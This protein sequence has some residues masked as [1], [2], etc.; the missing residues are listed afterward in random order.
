MKKA[1]INWSSGKDA[2]FT[3]YKVRKEGNFSVESLVTTINLETERISMHGVR[4]ELLESQAEQV[5][6]P[7]K[8][9]SLAGNVSMTSYNEIMLKQTRELKLQGYTHSIYGDIFLEDLKKYREDQLD[10]VGLT[11]VFP[12]WKTD[13]R[14][15]IKDFI[16]AGFKAKVVCVN[17]RLL[18]KSF[19]GREIDE[20]FLSS[21]PEG[22][23]PCGE[24]GEFHTFV[25]D[26]PVFKNPIRFEIGQVVQRSFQSSANKNDNCF[27]DQEKSW[28]TNFWYCDLL[29]Q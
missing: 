23:D 10:E 21:L 14:Q 7:L 2:A 8:L 6:L 12:I 18:N 26:G 25:Y 28:D 13:T 17:S 3:L 20:G 4:R 15:L 1:Y 11:A 19:C 5:G 27:S 16:N 9:I 24:N 29:P 22:V